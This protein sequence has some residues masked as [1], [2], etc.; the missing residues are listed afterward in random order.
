MPKYRGDGIGD[1]TD[2][3]IVRDHGWLE[4]RFGPGYTTELVNMEVE[5]EHRSKGIGTSMIEEAAS[6]VH[7][8]VLYGFV[9]HHNERMLALYKKLGFTLHP[10]PSFYGPAGDGVLVVRV[11]EK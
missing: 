4:I 11:R 6:F 10:I 5:P 2:R 7:S 3:V 8:K 9:Q 1:E